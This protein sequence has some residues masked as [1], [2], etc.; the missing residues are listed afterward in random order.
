MNKHR[1]LALI[2]AF[3]MTASAGVAQ[4]E[5]SQP[6]EQTEKHIS[7]DQK[8]QQWSQDPNQLNSERG[9]RRPATV[10]F[11]L[12]SLSRTVPVTSRCAWSM[13]TWSASRSGAYQKP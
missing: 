8:V 2:S 11:P 1:A 3:L 7:S 6:G 5:E 4:V 12:Y 10:T 9:D 13:K